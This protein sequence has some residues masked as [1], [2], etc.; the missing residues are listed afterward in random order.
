MYKNVS[1]LWDVKSKSYMNRNTKNARPQSCIKNIHNF[2]CGFRR[3]MKIIKDP[4][5]QDH[6]QM[7]YMYP[8]C[9]SFST[10]TGIPRKG[11]GNNDNA[12]DHELEE[13]CYL[14]MDGSWHPC[15]RPEDS[16]APACIPVRTRTLATSK[17]TL[18]Y[19][20][21]EV[22][23]N[24]VKSDHSLYVEKSKKLSSDTQFCRNLQ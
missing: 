19:N 2:R 3:D 21:W 5:E 8:T 23:A 24:S 20:N 10:D 9:S 1:C 16:R 4:K 15:W 18:Q 17:A 7:I 22:H 12:R 11:T 14:M 6:Q 13:L